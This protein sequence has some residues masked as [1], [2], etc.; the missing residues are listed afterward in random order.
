M[1]DGMLVDVIRGSHDAIFEFLFGCDADVPQ[2]GAGKFREEAVDQV[3]PR[4]VRPPGCWAEPARPGR[5]SGRYA[6]FTPRS[7]RRLACSLEQIVR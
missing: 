4:A 5:S 1:D 6:I 7:C 3:Q 2:D